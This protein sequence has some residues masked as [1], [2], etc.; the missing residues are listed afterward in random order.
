MVK[1]RALAAAW[2]ILLGTASACAGAEYRFAVERNAS[3]VT[4]QRDGSVDVEYELRFRCSPGGRPIDIVD[5]GL[6]NERYDLQTARAEFNGRA[7]SSIRQSE[8]VDCGVEIPLP[9]PIQPGESGTLYFHINNPHMVYQDRQ[10]ADY[11][12]IEFSP[13]W[14]DA[15]YAQ[16]TTDLSVTIRFPEGVTGEETRYHRERFDDAR[17]LDGRIAFTWWRR[18]AS[19]SRQ[20]MFGVSFPKKYVDV[21]YRE[22]RLAA[23]LKSLQQRITPRVLGGLVVVG[24][25]LIVAGLYKANERRKMD[26][27]PPLLAMEG[28]GVRRGLTAVEAA[29]LLEQPLD[30]IAAMILFGL[31]RKGVVA[32]KSLDPVVAEPSGATPPDLHQYEKTMLKAVGERLAGGPS[33]VAMQDI[34]TDLVRGVNDKLRGYNRHETAEYYRYIVS[35]AWRDVAAAQTAEDKLSQWEKN[36]D[37]TMADE[38]YG[39]RMEDTFGDEQQMPRR[40][41]WWMWEYDDARLDREAGTARQPPSLP[42]REFADRIVSR[43]ERLARGL[44]ADRGALHQA[45]TQETNPPTFVPAL[46][47]ALAELSESGGKGGGGGCACACACASCACACAGGGR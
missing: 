3:V 30:R 28:N 1:V 20:Y 32:L 45:V 14:Y 19:P 7:L 24:L 23:L 36:A 5:I 33:A 6:P 16:G 44:V 22:S 29:V 10:D 34:M 21:V 25:I 41:R 40:D 42:G 39:H 18:Q 8:V 9:Q 4:I 38:E 26:Y 43:V 2:L 47:K 15:R 12:G 27:M 46:K 35:K 13:T 17:E 31:E 11:A 37:W